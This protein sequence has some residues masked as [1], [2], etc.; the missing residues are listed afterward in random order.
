MDRDKF[1]S[2][3]EAKEF[4]IVDE[5]FEKRPAPAEEDAAKNAA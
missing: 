3:E 2:A 4:G 5:V 1:L